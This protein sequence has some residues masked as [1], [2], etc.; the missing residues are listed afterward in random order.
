MSEDYR[1]KLLAIYQRMNKIGRI[2]N[3]IS[4]FPRSSLEQVN[5]ARGH[6]GILERV[7][8]RDAVGDTYEHKE[9]LADAVLR[10]D[11]SLERLAASY[12]SI[13]SKHKDLQY[14]LVSDEEWDEINRDAYNNIAHSISKVFNVE[15]R[16]WETCSKR[17]R[18]FLHSDKE[19]YEIIEAHYDDYMAELR[20]FQDCMDDIELLIQDNKKLGYIEDLTNV[21]NVVDRIH[22]SIQKASKMLNYI[23]YGV[24]ISDD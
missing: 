24:A 5:V 9:Q 20:T 23:V 1:E 14:H 21:W 16:L 13:L 12:K 7:I 8:L 17:F 18:V 15:L 22:G 4:S 3:G 11:R 6:V 2:Q 19:W 10:T